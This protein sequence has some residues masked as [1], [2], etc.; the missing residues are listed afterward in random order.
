MDVRTMKKQLSSKDVKEINDQLKQKY[1]LQDFFDKHE[2]VF[3]VRDKEQ[4]YLKRNNQIVFFFCDQWIPTIKLLLTHQFLKAITVDKG[5]VKFVV[6]GAD[7]M[8]PGITAVDEAIQKDEIV[9]VVDETH[10]KPLAV[11][12]A[13]FSGV[14]IEQ[15]TSGK[16]IKNIHYVGDGV[17]KIS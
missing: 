8:R 2:Q 12:I 14:E 16:M 15:A 10:H 7:I 11:G 3:E 4:R 9:A 6:N 1:H 13:L 5:A 17:W